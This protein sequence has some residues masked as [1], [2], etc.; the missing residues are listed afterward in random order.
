MAILY[1]GFLEMEL[2][3]PT[4]AAIALTGLHITKPFQTLLA[5]KESTYSTLL[6]AL[7]LLYDDLTCIS[8]QTFLTTEKIVT[9][10]SLS[11]L[12]LKNV[13]WSILVAA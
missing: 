2:L 6:N 1:R 13:Y 3:K 10:I 9:F 12:V 8:P 4:Y 7:K 11:V 5:D